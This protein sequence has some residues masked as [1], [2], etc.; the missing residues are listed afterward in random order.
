MHTQGSGCHRCVGTVTHTQPFHVHLLICVHMSVPVPSA[1]CVG[2]GWLGCQ[3]CVHSLL[4]L[5]QF[6]HLS[7]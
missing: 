4:P 5:P 2:N 3:W 7:R 6:P 1:A